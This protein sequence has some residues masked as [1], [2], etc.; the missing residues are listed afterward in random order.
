MERSITGASD[1]A[2][3]PTTTRGLKVW[4]DLPRATFGRQDR[5]PSPDGTVRSRTASPDSSLRS[6]RGYITTPGPGAYSPERA[7]R[8][9]VGVP[10]HRYMGSPDRFHNHDSTRL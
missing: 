4:G 1:F 2:T 6:N 3:N 8:K 10:S 5:M 7:F 9:H